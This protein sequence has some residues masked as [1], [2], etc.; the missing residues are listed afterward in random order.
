MSGWSGSAASPGAGKRVGESVTLPYNGQQFTAA[1]GSVWLAQNGVPIAYTSDYAALLTEAPGVLS[2]GTLL[3]GP[4]GGFWGDYK[5]RVIVGANTEGA[6]WLAVRDTLYPDY[7]YT[8]VDAGATWTQRAY[9]VA[10]KL[11]A[12]VWDGTRFVLHAQGTA[13]TGV[14]ESVDGITWTPQTAASINTI[15]SV[16]YEGGVYLAWPTGGATQCAT[17]ADR[18]TWTYRTCV[19]TAAPP[20]I[21]QGLGYEP[22]WNAGAGLFLAATGVTAGRALYQTS[23]DGETWTSRTGLDDLIQTSTTGCAFASSATV[24]VAINRGPFVAYS[25]DGLNWTRAIISSSLINLTSLASA[26]YHDGTRFVV[27]TDG[28]IFYSTDGATWTLATRSRLPSGAATAIV[29]TPA[30]IAATFSS[31]VQFS[32]VTSTANSLVL[33]PAPSADSVT[34]SYVRIK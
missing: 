30:G 8:S 18:I 5:P 21:R 3:G 34:R 9:P 32:D 20:G 4:Y 15:L 28:L 31:M 11:W 22:S 23:P 19:S 27:V 33:P 26:L 16:Q 2:A 13:A 25:T 6:T 29:K 24:T 17:S 10:G 1:D 14:Q 7:Y 12:A